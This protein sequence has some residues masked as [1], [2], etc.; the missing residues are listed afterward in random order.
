MIRVSDGA[1]P[2]PTGRDRGDATAQLVVLV[3]VLLL[4]VLLVV[5]AALWYHTANIARASAA[6]GAGAGAPISADASVAGEAALA[7][8]VENGGRVVSAP[9]VA[10]DSRTVKV[11]VE[12]A[13]P[14]IVPFFPATVAR[15]QLEPR[16]RFIPENER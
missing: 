6:R 13:V 3:P 8:A 9:A 7:T 15:A 12:L 16:E 2:G 10:I 14:Q 4:M 1:A 11:V 5:Q